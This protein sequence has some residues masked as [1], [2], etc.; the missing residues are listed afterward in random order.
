MKHLR[1]VFICFIFIV[2]AFTANAESSYN[3]AEL[4]SVIK[5]TSETKAVGK[6]DMT[7]DVEYPYLLRLKSAFIPTGEDKEMLK[8]SAAMSAMKT[9]RH[10]GRICMF[11]CT[12]DRRLQVSRSVWDA[13][14]LWC[15]D[16]GRIVRGLWPVRL[17]L[18]ARKRPG[19]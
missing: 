15:S 7:I 5:P 3:I 8:N 1:V 13:H 11:I 14:A 17:R 18:P 2:S 10:C 4:Y 6:F 19:L 12:A 16:R 9:H